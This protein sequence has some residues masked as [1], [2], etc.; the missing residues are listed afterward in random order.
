M[1][2]LENL[3]GQRQNKETTHP[4]QQKTFTKTLKILK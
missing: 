4:L 2:Q 1:N 3:G